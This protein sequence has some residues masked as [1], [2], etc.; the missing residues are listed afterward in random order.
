MPMMHSVIARD[1][2]ARLGLSENPTLQTLK[3]RIGREIA[4]E[5]GTN[6]TA[7]FG[8]DGFGGNRHGNLLFDAHVIL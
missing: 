7:G 4:E 1:D 3:R 8:N 6:V 5:S 2:V